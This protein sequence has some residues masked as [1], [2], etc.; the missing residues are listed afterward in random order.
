MARQSGLRTGAVGVERSREQLAEAQRLAAS[1]NEADLVEFRQGSAEN[2]PL[3]EAEWGTFDVVHTRFL[4]EHV[5][6]P[7]AV[8]RQMVRA[9]R[10]GGRIILADDTHDTHRLWPEPPGLSR[11]WAA[12]LRTYDRVGNDPYVGHRLVSLL[13]EAGAK[14][15]RNTWLFFGACA[16]Q[17]ELL[18]AY[19]EN[20]ARIL[21]G[22]REPILALGEFDAATFDSCL[23]GIRAW[24]DRPD[25]AYWY[26]VAWA[27]GV[28]AT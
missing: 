18:A 16:G 13:F 6:D 23:A 1:E 2:L 7:A 5:R 19:V 8:V 21:E 14:P 4:L 3:R 10:P 17:P 25:A 11:L 22:V 27:E 20:L 12:Y 9:A 24:G 28:R 15:R 26:A